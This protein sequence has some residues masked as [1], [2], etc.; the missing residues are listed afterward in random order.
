MSSRQTYP[1]KRA[2]VVGVL[3]VA[4]LAVAAWL[5]VWWLRGS[6]AAPEEAPAVASSFL[7]EIRGDR[8]DSAWA[9]TTAEFKSFMGRERLH[10]F[11]RDHPSLRETAEASGFQMVSINGLSMAECI[12]RPGAGTSRIRILV[13]EEAGQWKVERLEVE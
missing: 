6:D 10:R 7:D 2:L 3:A 8:I 9:G 12:Y 5:A 1:R 13:R 11:V 4:A